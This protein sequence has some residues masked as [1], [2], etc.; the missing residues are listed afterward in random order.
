MYRK[1]C[2]KC[3]RPSFSSAGDGQWLCPV[4]GADLTDQK[5]FQAVS[6]EN[7]Q[8]KYESVKKSY[9]PGKK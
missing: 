1:N 3:H 9:S 7:S 6:I 8:Q 5:L 4:C 2:Y